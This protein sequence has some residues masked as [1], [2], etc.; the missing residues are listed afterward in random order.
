MAALHPARTS[1]SPLDK[2]SSAGVASAQPLEIIIFAD[3]PLNDAVARWRARA[4]ARSR[5][6]KSATP[7]GHQGRG[8]VRRQDNEG[9]P[10]GALG[11]VIDTS[12]PPRSFQEKRHAPGGGSTTGAWPALLGRFMLIGSLVEPNR[13]R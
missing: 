3:M 9:R 2:K 1:L 8:L 11:G 5:V 4:V 10:D 12:E 13:A 6:K 7:K